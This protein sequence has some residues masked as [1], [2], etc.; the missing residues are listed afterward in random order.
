[1]ANTENQPFTIEQ[2]SEPRLPVEPG[3]TVHIQS[4]Q[5]EIIGT[6]Q[7]KNNVGLGLQVGEA[8]RDLL[9]DDK[10]VALTYSMPYGVVSRRAKVCWLSDPENGQLKLGTSFLD[11]GDGFQTDYQKLWKQFSDADKLE[12]AA[13]A[14][15]ALQCAMISGVSRG[16]LV[17]GKPASDNYS[18][19]AFWPEGRRSSL[20]LTE[21]VELALHER[22]AVLRDQGQVD[23]EL[24]LRIC[25][26]AYPLMYGSELYGAIAIEMVVRAEHYMRSCMRQL[27]WGTAWLE[28]FVR[29]EE[30]KK[31]SPENQ[32]LA[33]VLDLIAVGLEQQNFQDAATAVATELADLLK[34]ERV[35]IG[36]LEKKYIRVRAISHSAQFADK[37]NLIAN[38]GLAMDEAMEQM[39]TL[40]CPPL[41]QQKVSVL[42][43]HE[44]MQ[45]EQGCGSICTIP[46]CSRNQVFGALTLEKPPGQMFEKQTIDLCETIASLIGPILESKRK[47]DLWL[48]RKAWLSLTEHYKHLVGPAHGGLKLGVA[49][50]V[51]VLLFAILA[52]GEYRISADTHL[53][54]E[55]QRAIAVP[56]D[57][58]I[59]EAH[60]RAGDVVEQGVLLAKLDDRELLLEKAKLESQHQQYLEEYRDAL[61]QSDR[62]KVSV[63]KAQLG[64]VEAQMALI[65]SQL[66]RINIKAPFSG[67]IVSGDLS[68]KLGSPSQRGDVLFEIAPLN[69]YR[70]ILEVDERD[71]A[72]VKVG[73]AGQLVLTGHA[74]Q[75]IPFV[76][77]KI[78]P[79]SEAKEGRNYFRVEASLEQS[80][81]YL[82]PGMK[83]VGKIHAGEH[84]LMWIWTKN[85]LDWLRL[86]F[87]TWWPD[88]L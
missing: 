66:S 5:Q 78:T 17:V 12:T 87:W 36:F 11:D 21:A 77:N 48:I 25:H 85:L 19:V 32:Q 61:G 24:G 68:Q 29:R 20:A 41:N 42:K 40:V 14:W 60:V 72:Y 65:E 35:S 49:L 18:P 45:R 44:K 52:T 46:F 16:V 37:S 13:Q 75:V 10:E 88:G 63:L 62:S 64:Q 55:I 27:Q 8:F 70:V 23:Q 74:Q 53:E 6:M 43:C 30:G 47:E 58:F 31:Y 79:V 15:L 33:T 3:T 22:R 67:V 26:I 28:L 80:P 86:T 50:S 82:R 69:A 57:G 56:F 81:A 7:D 71:I 84:K 39:D 1:M 59:N 73:Q 34:C 2:R 51:L 54:G 38:I 83:G 9:E 4:D 76:V